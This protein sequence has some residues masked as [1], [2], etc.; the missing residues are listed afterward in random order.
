M[1]SSRRIT[2][3]LASRVMSLTDDCTGKLTACRR[4][5]AACLRS[6]T[7]GNRRL[8]PNRDT[9]SRSIIT[10]LCCLA[11]HARTFG[12][13]RKNFSMYASASDTL[14]PICG[15]SDCALRP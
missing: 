6:T 3:R 13:M 10:W 1:P 9:T 12:I 5:S 14:T 15:A 7:I 11:I 4:I 8:R 2:R